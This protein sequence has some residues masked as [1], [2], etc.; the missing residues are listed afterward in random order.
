MAILFLI[1]QIMGASLGFSLLYALTPEEYFVSGL[2]V[3]QPH[4]SFSVVRLFFVEF[5]LTS[6]LVMIVCGVWDPRN[7]DKGDSAPLKI[8]DKINI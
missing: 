8:G 5:F 1:A 3:T 6:A 7:S 2:C 4:E